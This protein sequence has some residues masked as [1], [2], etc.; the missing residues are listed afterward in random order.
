MTGHAKGLAVFLTCAAA[1]P[2]ITLA[3]YVLG[4]GRDCAPV[5]GITLRSCVFG[6]SPGDAAFRLGI[7]STVVGMAIGVAVDKR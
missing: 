2:L 7:V 4:I 1:G 3:A 5:A 6:M